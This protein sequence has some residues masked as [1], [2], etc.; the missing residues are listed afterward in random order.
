MKCFIDMDGIVADLHGPLLR[1]LGRVWPSDAYGEDAWDLTRVLRL[2]PAEVWGPLDY[3]FWRHLPRTAEADEIVSVAAKA[4]GADNLCFLSS[5]LHDGG[6][7]EAKIDWAHEHYPGIPVLL[8]CRSHT[9]VIPKHFVAHGDAVLIDDHTP[10]VDAFMEHGGEGF[11]FPRPWNKWHRHERHGVHQ[12][13]AW[14]ELVQL[15]RMEVRGM[16]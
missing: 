3:H 11:V 12:L 4:F 8:S 14:A 7:S 6:C 15:G 1:R 9:G 10:N 2:S 5:P 16:L 13:G